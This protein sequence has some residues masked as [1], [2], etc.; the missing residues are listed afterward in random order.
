MKVFSVVPSLLVAAFVAAQ[1]TIVPHKPSGDLNGSNFTYPFPL[2]LYKFTSQQQHLE[3]AFMDVAPTST[4]NNKTAILF[5]GNFFCGATWNETIHVLAGIGYRVIVP[6]HI[7]YCKSTK[8]VGYQFS[9][10]Q[11]ATNANSLLQT[12]GIGNV[13][14]VGHSF[15]GMMTFRYGL[16]FPDSIDEMVVINAIGMEDYTA[17]GVPYLTI[18]ANF[19]SSLQSTFASIQSYENTTYYVGQWEDAYD[20]W[21]QMVIDVFYGSKRDA[22]NFNQA[23]IIDVV[24]TQPIAHE[25]ANVIPRVLLMIGEK[26]T[27]AIGKAWSPPS[28][29]ATLGNFTALA[30][31][32]SAQLPDCTLF[33]FPDLGHAPHISDPARFSAALVEW[34]TTG[35]I[36][37]TV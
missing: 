2:H 37:A 25:F 27:T 17:K 32:V 26:D 29:V 10:A 19:A 4:P 3:M 21:V 8:P 34:L 23:Q 14:V 12:L 16:M 13:T 24:L 1:G 5:H 35:A 31:D 11:L 36:N 30:L 18:D 7:G 6:D 33:T 22:F 15:G 20:V 9:V 28:V